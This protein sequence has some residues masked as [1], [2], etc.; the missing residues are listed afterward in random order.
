MLQ[1][2]KSF[3]VV[4]ID[5]DSDFDAAKFSLGKL[6]KREH[7]WQG[8]S[9]SVRAI[10]NGACRLC[11]TELAAKPKTERTRKNNVSPKEYL[12]S[13][14]T[15]DISGCWIWTGCAVDR[16]RAENRRYGAW[17]CAVLKEKT[18]HRAAYRI[19]KGE[20]SRDAVVMH[21]CDK[22]LCCNPDHLKVG[23]TEENNID[24]DKKGRQFA[25]SG[26][27]HPMAKINEETASLIK[28]RLAELAHIRNCAAII[29]KELGINKHIVHKIKEGKIWKSV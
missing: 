16:S 5:Q 24:R 7:K 25:L 20:L 4:M 26:S 10:S 2:N 23:T 19:F 28:T 17:T 22:P 29:A 13:R 11:M 6:C 3:F 14:I 27:N 18:A 9:Q 15:K 12:L 8:T 21:I 1:S